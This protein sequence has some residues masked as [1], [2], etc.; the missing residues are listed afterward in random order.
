MAHLFGGLRFFKYHTIGHRHLTCCGLLCVWCFC[1]N[2][3]ALATCGCGVFF[4]GGGGGE[5]D[6][7][8]PSKKKKDDWVVVSNIFY[9]HPYLG[10][11]E[12]EP[13][14]TSIFFRCGGRFFWGPTWMVP[15]RKLGSIGYFTYLYIG[16]FLGVKTHVL[17]IY[18]NY[19]LPGTSKLIL[20][21]LPKRRGGVYEI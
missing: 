5:V 18:C 4:L 10:I 21:H 20:G 8:S 2:F 7:E 16:V 19:W 11:G 3:R 14:L 1:F 12:D 13:I 6:T 15:G 9:F 17:A